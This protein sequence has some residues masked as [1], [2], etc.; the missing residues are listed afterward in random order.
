MLSR[1]EKETITKD[2]NE[3][4]KTN[5]S[6]FVLE[7]KGL[8]V[9]EMESF[10]KELKNADGELRVVKN[11]LLRIA[12]KDTSV[13]GLNDLFIGPTAIAIC[14]GEP[15]AVAKAISDNQKKFEPIV[16]KGGMVDGTVMDAQE[17]ER[18]AKL[19]PRDVLLSQL[20][21]LLSSPL[22]NFVGTLKQVQSG[23]LNVLTALKEKKE[24]AKEEKK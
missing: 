8:N 24:E 10:R 18:L 22:S 2:L 17:V 13:E 3:T 6:L 19:P 23:I 5:S 12:S 15:T 21:G 20:V 9:G 7:Y 1:A 4:F 14:S 11:T 16:I